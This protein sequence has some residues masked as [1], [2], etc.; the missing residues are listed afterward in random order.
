MENIFVIKLI[1]MSLFQS[2]VPD[3]EATKHERFSLADSM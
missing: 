1:S 2:G 3:F